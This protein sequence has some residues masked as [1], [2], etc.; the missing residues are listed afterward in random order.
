MLENPVRI[1]PRHFECPILAKRIYHHDLVSEIQALEAGADHRFFVEAG[2]NRAQ[3]RTFNAAASD[4]WI[5]FSPR[6]RRI[7][8][9]GGGSSGCLMRETL[10][11]LAIGC[12]FR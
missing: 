5:K 4:H 9:R 1:A 3:K 2:H 10:A 12:Q 6:V 7:S 8:C 11:D